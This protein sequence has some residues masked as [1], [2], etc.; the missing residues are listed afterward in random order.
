MASILRYGVAKQS[1]QNVVNEEKEITL[2]KQQHGDSRGSSP[3]M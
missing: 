3:T 1:V 2:N